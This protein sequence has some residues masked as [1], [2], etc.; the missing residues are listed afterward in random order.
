MIHARI[1]LVILNH[2]FPVARGGGHDVGNLQ[3]THS[4]CN[5]RKGAR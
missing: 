4:L 5:K 3:V 2:V 1:D